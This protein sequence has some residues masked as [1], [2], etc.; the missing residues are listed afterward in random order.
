MPIDTTQAVAPS[1]REFKIHARH[2]PAIEAELAARGFHFSAA[3]MAR[4]LARSESA[5]FELGAA[6]ADVR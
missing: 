2:L 5:V 3:L 1:R 4:A 6:D